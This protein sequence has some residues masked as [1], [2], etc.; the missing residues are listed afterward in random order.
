[1]NN[2]RVSD[3]RLK[4]SVS[5]SAP[6]IRSKDHV[7]DIYKEED[8]IDASLQI[9]KKKGGLITSVIQEQKLHAAFFYALKLKGPQADISQPPSS[10]TGIQ[11]VK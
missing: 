9:R 8:P 1:M 6:M 4:W 10:H 7:D 11:R 5:P 2:R 3:K